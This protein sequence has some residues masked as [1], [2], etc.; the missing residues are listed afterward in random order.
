MQLTY[1]IPE[2]KIT[3]VKDKARA[4]RVDLVLIKV[5]SV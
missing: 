3:I 5:T 2:I 1:R 4:T